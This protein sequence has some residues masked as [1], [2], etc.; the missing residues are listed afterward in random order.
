MCG[1]AEILIFTQYVGYSIQIN[2]HTISIVR[3][4]V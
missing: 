4:R 2:A 3:Q 1:T